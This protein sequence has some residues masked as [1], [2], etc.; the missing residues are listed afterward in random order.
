MVFKQTGF[1]RWYIPEERFPVIQSSLKAIPKFK[2][3][4]H[5]SLI[6][7]YLAAL[8]LVR[9]VFIHSLILLHSLYC[10][11]KWEHPGICG[12]ILSAI[13]RMLTT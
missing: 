3:A 4:A 10:S 2:V 1:N 6:G 13:R 11:R 9:C 5:L 7:H 8:F 12:Y